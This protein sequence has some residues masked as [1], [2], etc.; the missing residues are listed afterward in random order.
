MSNTNAFRLTAPTNIAAPIAK[1]NPY[2]QTHHGKTHEDDYFWLK[3]QGYPNVTDE[4]ILSY[5]REENKYYTSVMSEKSGLTSQLFE[6][7]KGRIKED[8]DGV[9]WQ[10]GDY[11]Y[12]W[13]FKKGAQYR[14][15]YRRPR[16]I[17][18]F[19][20]EFPGGDW[21]V[22]LD[23]ASEAAD[24][25]FFKLGDMAI[26]PDGHLMAF[27]ADTNGSERFT[28]FVRNLTTGETL[29]DQI[30]ES[31]G[32]IVWS[33]NSKSF[34]CV[35]V[36]EEWRP[37]LVLHHKLGGMTSDVYEE[38]D[39]S[40]FVHISETSSKQYLVIRSAD[41]VTAESHVLS[42]HD[43]GLKTQVFVGRQ[44]D[45]D[46]YLDHGI[47][48]FIVRSN[49]DQ[50]NFSLYQAK[51]GEDAKNWTCVHEGSANRYIRGFQLFETFRV[52]QERIDGLDQILIQ[53]KDG[54]AFHI[55]MPEA[56]YEA[57]IGNNPEYSQTH[58]RFGY[59]SMITPPTVFDF[60][61][62]ARELVI[63][64]EQ[65]IPSGYDKSLYQTERLMVEARDGVKVPV[66]VVY[67]KDWKKN[68]GA[69]LHL[70]GYG[71]YGLGMSPSFSSTR[72]SLLD[73]EFAYAIAHIRG[74]DELGYTWY[75]A[76]KL[77][78]RENTFNDFVDVAR[79]LTES[80]Y[81]EKGGIS[82]SGGS[83]GGELMGA[84]LNQA[85]ELFK[86]AVLHVPFVDVLNTMLDKDLPLTPI[87]WPEWGNPIESEAAYDHIRS[88]CPY[89][90]IVAKE[91]PP[92]MVT[93]G[94]NDPRVTYW[95]PAKWTAKMRAVKS[96]DNLLVMKINMEA[97]HGGKSGR[98]ERIHEVAEEYTFLL[99]AFDKTD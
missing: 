82:I 79:Y 94:I 87:E 30:P 71:A 33:Q 36:S 15:W 52:V 78:R 73:R 35:K 31:S 69:P 95:E 25:D 43:T 89:T 67:H 93:G 2:T 84:V 99:M 76:G 53:P 17:D 7:V 32:E 81:A 49:K 97:G 18:A 42:L 66:S 51:L 96:D 48:G 65:E 24:K 8:E 14:T 86:A 11:E 75:Q 4:E 80:G 56:A 92:M 34:F 12:R 41:H 63:R 57:S 10:D 40:F 54:E 74:G 27:S 23:E 19:G 61:L 1:R 6:E 59:S 9:P 16:T 20:G 26:S 37:Y 72:L 98:F 3:D 28:I 60:D 45:H 44:T 38:Q 64:K 88:Y 39:T 50:V 46:Y 22:I 21:D 13:A 58:L 83:A 90:N 68:S 47:D 70:Y 55:D 85:P 5:L 91:Y 29:N 77:D 62:A